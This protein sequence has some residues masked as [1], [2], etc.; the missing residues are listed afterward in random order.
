[1]IARANC[2]RP[3]PF[4]S[5]I[6]QSCIT[7][8]PYTGRR[9][10]GNSPD[11]IGLEAFHEYCRNLTI[12]GDQIADILVPAGTWWLNI[13]DF[14]A[15]S[16]GAGGDYNEGGSKEGQLKYRQGRPT[17]GL[18]TRET[19]SGLFGGASLD[20]WTHEH[21]RL[22]PGN[23]GLAP[24]HVAAH[25]QGSGWIVRKEIVWDK[26][27]TKPED[28]SHTRR[29]GESHET[30]FMLT[31][32]MDYKF[33]P[34]AIPKRRLLDADEIADLPD[35]TAGRLIGGS[36]PYMIKDGGDCW[37]GPLDGK[38]GTISTS[39]EIALAGGIVL[40]V[41]DSGSVW[42][43]ASGRDRSDADGHPAVMP[44]AFAERCILLSTDPGDVVFD[45]FAGSGTTIDA[46]ERLGR[47]G[48]GVDL[49][50][51]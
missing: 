38:L 45:P 30:L 32:S 15:G 31:R 41:N 8:P 40:S 44:D 20:G 14:A 34:D 42:H 11:E 51:A 36:R 9:K 16:G 12:V 33:N 48:L 10:Y 43:I 29:P 1:M 24:F 6:A 27:E 17:I 46:A 3:L 5:G 26:N 37:H 4:R 19:Q 13:G 49:Y 39:Y 2:A 18:P 21:T 22:P 28:P 23:W 25:L 50:A 7:S 35:G 47:V